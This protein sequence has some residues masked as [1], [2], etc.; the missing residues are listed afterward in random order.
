[1]SNTN[2]T[3]VYQIKIN[4]ENNEE[5]SFSAECEILDG[6]Y[7]NIKPIGEIKNIEIFFE[8]T[9]LY[10]EG[11]TRRTHKMLS[12]DVILVDNDNNETKLYVCM[13]NSIEFDESITYIENITL[14]YQYM[15]GKIINYIPPVNLRIEISNLTEEH[16]NKIKKMFE[17]WKILVK[18]NETRWTSFY[19]P[20]DF[21]P[22]IDIFYD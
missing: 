11:I 7:F 19:I 6:N 21:S 5:C 12:R 1:M 9:R 13:V 22:K 20:K 8:W 17:E 3:S 18:K 15:S 4:N 16:A 10:S 14:S 2:N